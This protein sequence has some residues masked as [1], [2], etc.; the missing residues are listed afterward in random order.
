MQLYDC[1]S[2]NDCDNWVDTNE[3]DGQHKIISAHV[4]VP[5]MN[6]V[7]KL[8]VVILISIQTTMEIKACLHN[9]E[10]WWF[11]SQGFIVWF[12]YRLI[13]E[14]RPI[15]ALSVVALV[16]WWINLLEVITAYQ[17]PRFIPF[18]VWEGRKGRVNLTICAQQSTKEKI[19]QEAVTVSW[20]VRWIKMKGSSV[21]NPLGFSPGYMFRGVSIA[22]QDY[23]WCI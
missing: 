23:I 3:V 17:S 16:W 21:T 15:W 12:L 2:A 5:H 11:V 1:R 18:L 22:L 13:S 14:T 4:S 6:K 20:Q 19:T 7:Q 9:L 10:C 8:G